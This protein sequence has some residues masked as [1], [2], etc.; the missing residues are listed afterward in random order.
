MWQLWS[1]SGKGLGLLRDSV[2]GQSA[3]QLDSWETSERNQDLDPRCNRGSFPFTLFKSQGFKSPKP[4]IK[5]IKGCLKQG[6]SD[7]PVRSAK[8]T[9]GFIAN[10]FFKSQEVVM[11]FSWT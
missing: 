4:T 6:A 8:A 3:S 7:K 1:V 9:S 5:A 2:Q 10:S 11:D